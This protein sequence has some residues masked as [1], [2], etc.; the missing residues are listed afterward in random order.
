MRFGL[1]HLECIH[2][3]LNRRLCRIESR[4]FVWN[5][6]RDCRNADE[7]DDTRGQLGIA[8][9]LAHCSPSELHKVSLLEMGW[10]KET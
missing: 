4:I 10:D 2:P 1:T 3:G 6:D 7:R 9:S 5:V 8:A